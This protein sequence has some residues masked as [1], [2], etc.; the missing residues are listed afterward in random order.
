MGKRILFIATG[1]TIASE[2]TALGLKPGLSAA[3]LLAAVPAIGAL[4]DVESLQLYDLDSTDIGPEHWLGMA[5]VIRERYDEFDGFVLS[6]G[7]D[8]MAYSAAALSY[9][10]TGQREANSLHGRAKAYGFRHHGLACQPLR[11]FPLRLPGRHARGS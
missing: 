8:T 9:S 7:T 5:K 1:G 11:Q 10:N 2:V 6:H 4:C 3:A